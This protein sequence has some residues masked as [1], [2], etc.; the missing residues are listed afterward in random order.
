MQY[1]VNIVT[2]LLTLNQAQFAQWHSDVGDAVF[3]GPR[4]NWWGRGKARHK[5]VARGLGGLLGLITCI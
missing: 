3:E 4:K 1:E 2:E 5:Q